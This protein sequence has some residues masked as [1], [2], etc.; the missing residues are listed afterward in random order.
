MRSIVTVDGV[1][2]ASVLAQ[3]VPG[4]AR[5]RVRARRI[6]A[7]LRARLLRDALVAVCGPEE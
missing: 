4:H 1:T 7:R 2:G 5:A 3:P 6:R